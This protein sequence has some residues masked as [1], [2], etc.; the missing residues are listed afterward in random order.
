MRYAGG[1]NKFANKLAAI[2]G[3]GEVLVEPF[4][5]G[6]AMTAALAPSFDI[7]YAYDNHPDLILMWQALL[8]GWI[9]PDNVTEEEY[10]KLKKQHSSPLR[11]FAG[12]AC[13]FGG[14]WMTGYSVDLRSG[15]QN[16]AGEAKRLLMK[17][18][19]RMKNVVVDMEDY[20]NL[21][22]P[23]G[24]IVYADPPYANAVH[25]KNP[26]EPNGF[27]SKEFWQ[28]ASKWAENATVFV[29]EFVAPPDWIIVW[30]EERN[31]SMRNNDSYRGENMVERLFCKG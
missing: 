30:E 16:Y 2:V 29:S 27:N 26:L 1:K 12:F 3:S 21:V 10:Y 14:A 23:P 4:I 31:R 5:G 11:G 24:A 6:G 22:I 19:K 28:V 20:R 8:D 7:V 9:P 17:K 13:A 18:V 15:R 25:Y